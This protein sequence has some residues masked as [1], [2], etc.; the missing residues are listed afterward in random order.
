[1]RQTGMLSDTLILMANSERGRDGNKNCRPVRRTKKPCVPKGPGCLLVLVWSSVS[2]CLERRV[3]N[4]V[5]VVGDDVV[6]VVVTP[7]TTPPHADTGGASV[8]NAAGVAV[9]SFWCISASF[10]EHG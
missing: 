1:M 3:V 4:V 8:C 9:V 6:V 5:A 10:R 7:T 2:S